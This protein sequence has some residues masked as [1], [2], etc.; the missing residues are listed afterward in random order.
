MQALNIEEFNS[1]IDQGYE[2][3]DFRTPDDFANGF[4]PNSFYINPQ[5]ENALVIYNQFVKPFNK[6]V[7]IF[8]NNS[9]K[10]K[11]SI[12]QNI[13]AL[14]IE[15]YLKGG[16]AAWKNH[17]S[18]IDMLITIDA[19]EFEMDLKHDRQ[20]ELLDIRNKKQFEQV[21]LEH[22]LHAPLHEIPLLI[23]EL[24]PQEK[25]YLL[26]DSKSTSIAA[27]AYFNRHGIR[28]TRILNGSFYELQ[29]TSLPL[30]TKNKEAKSPRNDGNGK[31][32]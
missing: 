17:T 3:V 9:P 15:A 27:A 11:N 19:D 20:I 30:V 14:E 10:G 32:N 28:I 4:V 6:F 29:Q 2:V 23:S 25:Y 5:D 31:P 1:R 21:H 8:P 24:Q 26:S 13:H 12:L 16:I 7:G 18:H 22:T